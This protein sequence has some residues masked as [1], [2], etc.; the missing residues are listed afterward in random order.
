M[1]EYSLVGMTRFRLGGSKEAFIRL[2]HDLE[3]NL[4]R[5][6]R[7]MLGSEDELPA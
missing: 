2:I 3:M 5:L 6:A 1:T 7:S 4:Y